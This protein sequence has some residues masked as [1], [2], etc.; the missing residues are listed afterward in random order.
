MYIAPQSRCGTC[1]ARESGQSK[2][3]GCGSNAPGVVR[4]SEHEKREKNR[5]HQ[6]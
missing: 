1:V 6:S 3:R 2:E 4:W 5:K